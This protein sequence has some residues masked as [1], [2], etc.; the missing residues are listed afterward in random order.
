M[1]QKKF[2]DVL[3]RQAIPFPKE[4]LDRIEVLRNK[5]EENKENE[6]LLNVLQENNQ[7]QET[8]LVDLYNQES[9]EYFDKIEEEYK[10]Y[11]WEEQDYQENKWLYEYGLEHLEELSKRVKM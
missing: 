3:V 6:S 8:S 11:I 9:S 5:A 1:T 4:L 2:T 10:H 7:P